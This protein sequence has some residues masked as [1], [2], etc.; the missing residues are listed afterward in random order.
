MLETIR[1]YA[2]DR[3]QASGEQELLQSRHLDA[4][5]RLTDQA[6]LHVYDAEQ[7]TWFR[8]LEVELPKR[9]E[10]KPRKITVAVK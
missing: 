9:E 3:L 5:A 4:F 7:A 1:Q 10:A 8:R 2:H 6:T